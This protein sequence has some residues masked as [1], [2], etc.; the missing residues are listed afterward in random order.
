[1]KILSPPQLQK[2]DQ[3]TIEELNIYSID[4]MEKA[5]LAFVAQYETLFSK[6][7]PVHIFCGPGNNGGDGLAIARIL[8]QKKYSVAVYLLKSTRSYSPDNIINQQNLKNSKL[9]I[10]SIATLKNLPNLPKDCIIIDA[11]FGSGLNQPLRGISKSVVTFINQQAAIK[12]AVDIP[13]GLFANEFTSEIAVEAD[14]VFTFQLPK[15]AFLL[16]SSAVFVK[17]W[18]LLDIGLSAAAIALEETQY[19][20]LTLADIQSIFQKRNRFSHKGT[21]GHLLLIAG[22]KGKV[23]AA[24]LSGKA[25][26]R[27]GVGLLTIFLPQKL[28]PIVQVALPEAMCLTGKNS[29]VIHSLKNQTN[30]TIAIGPG[31]GQQKSTI[32]FLKSILKEV[33]N[34]MVVDADG[35][36]ILSKHP[37]WFQNLPSQ[38]ILTP[39]PGEFKRMVGNWENDFHKLQL[40]Q[41]FAIKHQII[42]V[43]KG[44]NTCICD[45]DGRLYF[46]STGNSGMATAGSGDT[47]TGII[48]GLLAQGYSP[49]HAAQLGVFVHGL[50]GDLAIDDEH[51]NSLIA[52]DITAHLGLAFKQVDI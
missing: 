39:H 16:P 49:L 34:P 36:N 6:I 37:E 26:L 24:I 40:L 23:G 20:Y 47:L 5:S 19:E 35:L 38:S 27:S 51:P 7:L 29:N 1:M 14:H 13:S 48:A 15:L 32:A 21:Y 31:I 33:K 52:S 25:A 28:I 11:L 18:H 17:Q 45:I 9:K 30:Q 44:E 4:L 22:S 41:D 12:V 2:V 50:A 46:N 43:L 3:S 8:H 10:N 42:V